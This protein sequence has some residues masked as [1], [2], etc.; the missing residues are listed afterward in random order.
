AIEYHRDADNNR[1]AAAMRTG[2]CH[3][4]G[5]GLG[6]VMIL[7]L[8]LLAFGLLMNYFVPANRFSLHGMYRQRLVR[9]FLGAS[10][11]NR[12]PNPFT[13]FDVA[14]DLRVH[15]LADVRPLHVINATLNAVSSTK[16]SGHEKQA[17]S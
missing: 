16:V 2:E 17:E 3:T 4:A 6:E 1:C 12:E 8:S 13:G 15:D 10:R 5:G 9:T 11:A 7:A 14:D